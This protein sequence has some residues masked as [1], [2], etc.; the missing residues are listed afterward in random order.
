[1]TNNY[2][3]YYD[4]IQEYNI[5][6]DLFFHKVMEDA[7]AAEELLQIILGDKSIKVISCTPQY[8]LRNIGNRSVVLDLLCEDADGRFFNV[9]IQQ[10]DN[11]DHQKRMRYHISNLDTRITEKG[12]DFADLPEVF[13]IMISKFDIFKLGK[14]VYHIDRVLREKGSVEDNGVHEI[15][16]NA[17][18][19]DKSEVTELMQY[20]LDSNGFDPRFPRISSRVQYFK[21]DNGGTRGMGKTIAELRAEGRAEGL[22]EG[23]EKG[24]EKGMAKGI[25]KGMAKA[26]AE[27]LKNLGIS[28]EEYRAILK[29]KAAKQ[30]AD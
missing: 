20:V 7:G 15:Y 4:Q 6:D 18:G 27:V 1:M 25:Q 3:E 29:S 5:I 30:K 26:T 2:S 16:V 21:Q 24:I 14:T 19:N 10:A 8:S 9:E 22:A 23:M 13:S 11:T 28:Q 12:V 17:T